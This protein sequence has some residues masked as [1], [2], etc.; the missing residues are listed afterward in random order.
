MGPDHGHPRERGLRVLDVGCGTGAQTLQLARHVE[1]TIVAIDNHQPYLDEL[2]RRAGAERLEG[3][4]EL[5]LKDMRALSESD[6][7][8]DLVW[9]EG[10]LF[11]MGFKAGLEACFDR[12]VPGGLA[13]VSE[14]VWLSA[15]QPAE[16]RDF[17]AG[18]YPAML[19]IAG[20]EMLIADSGF[21]LVDEF[22]LPDS[23][24][25]DGYYRPLEV[26]LEQFRDQWATDPEKRDMLEWIQAEIDIRRK[27]PASYGNMFFLLR[28]PER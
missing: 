19:D 8:F 27:Y 7:F 3:K 6:G 4:I 5:R 25:W 18:G 21:E 11:V 28:R 13:A 15:D 26:R 2:G 23:S 14:L 24:W 20:T 10:S 16:C 1:V 22:L 17:F 12:L 9:A